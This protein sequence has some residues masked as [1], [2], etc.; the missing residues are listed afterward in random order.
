MH[1]ALSSV[2]SD[3]NTGEQPIIMFLLSIL[4]SEFG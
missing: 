4:S 1:C 3:K 2:R